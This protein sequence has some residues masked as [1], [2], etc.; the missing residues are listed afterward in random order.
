MIKHSSRSISE[1]TLL[2]VSLILVLFSGSA[3]AIYWGAKLES[4]VDNNTAALAEKTQGDSDTAKKLGEIAERLS[5]IE[6]M[7]SSLKPKLA[8]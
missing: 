8:K 6:G 3:Y 7:L 5:N 4:R 1:K 2:P